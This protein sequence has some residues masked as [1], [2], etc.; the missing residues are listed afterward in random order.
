MKDELSTIWEEARN[1]ILDGDYDKAEDIYKYILLRYV[2]NDVAVEH[3]SAYLGDLY[4]TMGQRLKAVGYLK[5]ALEIQPD[6]VEY[7]Y[8]LGFAYSSLERW[9]E[10]VDELQ[11]AADGAPGNVE[12]KR[13]LGWAVFNFGARDMGLE[14][15]REALALAPEDVNVV[16]DLASAYMISGDISRA[17]EYGRQALELDP[18]NDLAQRLIYRVKEL[19]DLMTR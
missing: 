2:D 12:Y 19:R 6:E 10:A 15:L 16:M 7:H 17:E 8:L 18:H 1:H 5:K 4:L 11:E 3:A 14:L 13:S 9:A